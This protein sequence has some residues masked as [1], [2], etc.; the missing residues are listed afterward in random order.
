M[1]YEFCPECARQLM[2]V[3]T[4]TALIVWC[5]NYDCPGFEAYYME[6]FA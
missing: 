6:E 1:Q 4:Q 3:F 5:E 2:S